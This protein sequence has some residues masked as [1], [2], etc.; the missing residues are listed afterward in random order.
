MTPFCVCQ[1]SG[2]GVKGG[3]GGEWRPKVGG[4]ELEAQSLQLEGSGGPKPKVY[5]WRGVEAQ[6]LQL[7]GSGGPKLE[8]QSWRP[9]VG[10]LKST[11]G[12]EWR[13]KVYSWRG[14]EAQSWRPKVGGLK[15][16]FGCQELFFVP[17]AP[18]L[19]KR[20]YL[21]ACTHARTHAHTHTQADGLIISTPSG[22]T[23]YSMSAGG[24]MVAPSVPCSILTPIA[25]LSLSFRCV[26]VCVCVYVCAQTHTHTYIYMCLLSRSVIVSIVGWV[27]SSVPCSILTPIAPLS[28]SFR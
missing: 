28:L 24:P 5:S 18:H 15:S 14:V 21:P 25:P 12:G 17:L 3:G 6:S 20:R 7:E 13:P 2:R 8:A 19:N 26:C 10:G 27:A 22:S 16:T 1:E 4:P 9:K 11:F 23:A